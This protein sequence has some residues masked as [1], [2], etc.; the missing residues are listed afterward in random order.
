ML[1]V[2]A[3]LLLAG[4]VVGVVTIVRA[5]SGGT[6]GQDG[7]PSSS[8]SPTAT[9]TPTE[10]PTAP[11]PTACT[12]EQATLGVVVPPGASAGSGTTATIEVSVA[13]DQPCLVN[14]G[15]EALEVEVYSGEDLVWSSAQCPFTPAVRELLLPGGATDVQ[16]VRWSG[17]HSGEGC[18][19]DVTASAGTYRMVATQTYEG[20][21]LT[22]EA[23]FQL[24][25]VPEPEPDP[26]VSAAEPEGSD[27][28]DAGEETA[29]GSADD[30]TSRN[31][32]GDQ[33]NG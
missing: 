31:D 10:Q 26:E 12:A 24:V 9:P 18:A 19:S 1:G 29:D 16:K 30:D 13:G 6:A 27:V 20:E 3:L 21:R 15:S 2:L 7:A 28:E 33:S 14:L 4:I 11:L 23:T 22:G 5:V 32:S 17:L 8:P 25:P